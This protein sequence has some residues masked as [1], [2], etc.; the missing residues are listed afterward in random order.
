MTKSAVNKMIS[1][2]QF[3]IYSFLAFI[4]SMIIISYALLSYG[5]SIPR[6]ILP[7]F[8]AEQLYIKLDKKLNL[9]VKSIDVTI[10]NNENSDDSLLDLPRMSPIINLARK[11]FESFKIK[12]LRANN[13]IVT[14]S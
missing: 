10:G 8:K 2:I 3:T 6:I 12:E 14:F 13:S 7:G 9:Y 4:F 5:V 11:N 1:N